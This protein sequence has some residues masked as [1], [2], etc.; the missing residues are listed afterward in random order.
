MQSS[1]P[2]NPP[3]LPLPRASAS[4][5]EP[6]STHL[7]SILRDAISTPNVDDRQLRSEFRVRDVDETRHNGLGAEMGAASLRDERELSKCPTISFHSR[8]TSVR[9]NPIVDLKRRYLERS[10]TSKQSIPNASSRSQ[11]VKS[12]GTEEGES[13]R[14]EERAEAGRVEE[15]GRDCTSSTSCPAETRISA[16]TRA[17][18]LCISKP[19]RRESELPLA[20]LQEEED[21]S[22]RE[23]KQIGKREEMGREAGEVLPE[24][25]RR[26]EGLHH[27]GRVVQWDRKGYEDEGHPSEHV[28]API[29]PQDSILALD[30][31]IKVSK[32][33]ERSKA[34]QTRVFARRSPRARRWGSGRGE[35][36]VKRREGERRRG[37][38][39]IGSES[40]ERG[41]EERK[42]CAVGEE[43]REAEDG[44]DER[45][46]G[47]RRKLAFR[48][49]AVSPS[50]FL[51]NPATRG[52]PHVLGVKIRAPDGRVS[53]HPTEETNAKPRTHKGASEGTMGKGPGIWKY[54]PSSLLTASF[55]EYLIEYLPTSTRSTAAVE[56]RRHH[57]PTRLDEHAKSS[58]RRGSEFDRERGC[59]SSNV[60]IT[61]FVSTQNEELPSS[62]TSKTNYE[63]YEDLGFE[64]A[65]VIL[66]RRRAARGA[67]QGKT[68]GIH[69]VYERSIDFDSRIDDLRRRR[70]P[71]SRPRFSCA[72]AK[73]STATSSSVRFICERGSKNEGPRFWDVSMTTA[74]A[75]SF[76]RRRRR[77]Y[78]SRPPH[79]HT[80]RNIDDLLASLSR[81]SCRDMAMPWPSSLLRVNRLV[82][83]HILSDLELRSL[84]TGI[85]SETRTRCRCLSP[86]SPRLLLGKTSLTISSSTPP[87]FNISLTLPC[88][89]SYRSASGGVLLAPPLLTTR[90]AK[91]SLLSVPRSLHHDLCIPRAYRL[92][93]FFQSSLASQ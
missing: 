89:P 55:R 26:G 54:N 77:S 23:C 11:S 33:L 21:G 20:G 62:K 35:E 22:E 49:T 61:D 57:H 37:R 81:S 58:T 79:A 90:T 16:S 50:P 64:E 66:G 87:I 70:T 88:C 18:G 83:T 53:V 72:S 2:R 4:T 3:C 27:E 73:L 34:S 63:G 9:R 75:S 39:G 56:D 19:R 71:A 76:R 92:P 28:P 1:S 8:L 84:A 24:G 10:R 7:N 32:D 17:P 14:M 82:L 15:K 65:F 45:K 30:A 78:G 40:R 31:S 91:R 12:R 36:E 29:I 74:I 5:A 93:P 25:Q 85:A 13:E 68:N 67:R 51:S 6:T 38:E 52:F 41:R 60:C 44:E 47:K 69:K 86:V 46:E 59:L 48:S 43:R 80:K 42:D